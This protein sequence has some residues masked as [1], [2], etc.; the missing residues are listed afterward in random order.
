MDTG[1]VLAAYAKK[2]E[3]GE[4]LLNIYNSLVPVFEESGLYEELSGLLEKIYN[5]TKKP[6][7]FEKI[8]DIINNKCMPTIPELCLFLSNKYFMREDY[9]NSILRQKMAIVQESACNA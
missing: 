5:I 7:L 8:G 6:S 9:Y 3:N 2:I 1:K 4:E